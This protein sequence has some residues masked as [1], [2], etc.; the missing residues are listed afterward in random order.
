MSTYIFLA[1]WAIYG[2]FGP[3]RLSGDRN[4]H[5]AAFVWLRDETPGQHQPGIDVQEKGEWRLHKIIGI[6]LGL[7]AAIITSQSDPVIAF[8]APVLVT[9][10]GDSLSRLVKQ[11]DWA[12]HGA[13][14]LVAEDAGVAGY[15]QQEAARVARDYRTSTEQALEWFD[16]VLWL[17]KIIRTLGY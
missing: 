3:F 13:E 8:V 17:S 1:I 14:V 9:L 2:A 11:I 15:R 16:Q 5:N 12:G 6:A 4:H 10:I 7:L